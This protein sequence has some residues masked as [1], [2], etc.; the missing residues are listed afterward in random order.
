MPQ[1]VGDVREDRR[2]HQD[3]VT[4]RLVPIALLTTVSTTHL[5]QGIVQFHGPTMA[6]L[7]R[8]FSMSSVTFRIV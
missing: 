5:V 7:K 1:L 8:K 4:D 2:H 6:V 3:Q